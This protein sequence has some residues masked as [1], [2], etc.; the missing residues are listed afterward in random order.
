MR[1][2]ILIICSVFLYGSETCRI[3]KKEEKMLVAFENKKLRK[4]KENGEG[5]AN[6]LI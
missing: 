6:I 2:Y 5:I 3:R 4:N 1:L